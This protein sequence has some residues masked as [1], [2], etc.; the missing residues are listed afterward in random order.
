MSKDL[1]P[2]TKTV[3]FCPATHPPLQLPQQHRG[4]RGPLDEQKQEGDYF[5]KKIIRGPSYQSSRLQPAVI[6]TIPR[7]SNMAPHQNHRFDYSPLKICFPKFDKHFLSPYSLPS[8]MLGAFY[9][10]PIPFSGVDPLVEEAI[11]NPRYHCYCGSSPP[12]C[13]L[14]HLYFPLILSLKIRPLLD[15]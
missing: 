15:E 13:E 4:R 12:N 6:F 1:S 7:T 10:F 11:P 5:F 2:I 8:T 3:T 9:V 14:F